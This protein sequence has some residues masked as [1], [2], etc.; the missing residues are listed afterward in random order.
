[1]KRPSAGEPGRI[2]DLDLRWHDNAWK[3]NPLSWSRRQENAGA[4]GRDAGDTRTG[5]SAEPQWQHDEDR[6]ASQQN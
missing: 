2:A 5:R 3:K 4:S 1:M 6:I